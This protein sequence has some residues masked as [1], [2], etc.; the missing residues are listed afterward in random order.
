VIHDLA[1]RRIGVG[2]NLNQIKTGLRGQ[3][4]GA[5]RG[6]NTNVFTF[7]ADQADF[8]GPDAFIDAWACVALRGRVMWTAGYGFAPYADCVNAAR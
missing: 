1:D 8:G 4:H 2:R 5:G 6:D 3:I 7:G